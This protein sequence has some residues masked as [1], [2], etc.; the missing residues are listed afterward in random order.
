[1]RRKNFGQSNNA[2]LE[3]RV[4]QQRSPAKAAQ[5]CSFAKVS[6]TSRKSGGKRKR[7]AKGGKAKKHAVGKI[8]SYSV[9]Q[10]AYR[11]KRFSPS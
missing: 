11:Q 6:L 10:R 8:V 7:K 9:L 5:N 3:T 2:M 1:M 4:V